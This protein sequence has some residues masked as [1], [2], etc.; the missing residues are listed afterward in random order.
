MN[1]RAFDHLGRPVQVNGQSVTI[2]AKPV[3]IQVR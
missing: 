3:Y 1:R 2:D